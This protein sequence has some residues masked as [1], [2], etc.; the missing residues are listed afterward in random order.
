MKKAIQIILL[1][2]FFF[3]YSYS[4]NNTIQIKKTY[5]KSFYSYKD[6]TQYTFNKNGDITESTIV[7]LNDNKPDTTSQIT[8]KYKNSKL[9]E[10]KVIH[11]KILI[12]NEKYSYKNGLLKSINYID[13]EKLN[14]YYDSNKNLTFDVMIKGLD[15]LRTITYKYKENE[16]VELFRFSN[17]V[18][19][20][21]RTY[22]KSNDT[23]MET[24][25]SHDSLHLEK[26]KILIN[27]KKFNS[28]NLLFYSS[29]NLYDNYIVEKKY[30]Y[31]TK[32]QLVKINIINSEDNSI[33]KERYFFTY[34]N[35]FLTKIESQELIEENWE[36][37]DLIQLEK[38]KMTKKSKKT[39][40]EK[41]NNYLLKEYLDQ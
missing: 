13:N 8:Y 41:I 1:C 7:Y 39:T 24:I 11:R 14:C 9:R 3:G 33:P 15:T 10:R 12:L 35:D 40:I 37:I 36:T 38:E 20:E 4:Q 28:E 31:N 30:G 2:F 32:N 25:Y 19:N 26:P 5:L 22:E 34:E 27:K 6:L 18:D 17:N 21:K 16:L 23:L 29:K